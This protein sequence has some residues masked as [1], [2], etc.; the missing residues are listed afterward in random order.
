MPLGSEPSFPLDSIK[1]AAMDF[2]NA[3]TSQA[4]PTPSPS[5]PTYVEHHEPQQ[6]SENKPPAQPVQTQTEGQAQPEPVAEDAAE[7]NPTQL[8]RVTTTVDGKSVTEVL[9]G[10]QLTDRQMNARKFTQSMQ[11]VR[12]MERQAL[13]AQRG[14]AAIRQRQAEQDSIMN[15]PGRLAAYVQAKFPQILTPQQQ[16]QAVAAQ[17]VAAPTPVVD[18]QM[19]A[20]VGDVNDAVARSIASQEAELGR[21]LSGMEQAAIQRAEESASRI[22]QQTI[23]NLQNSHQVATFDRQIEDHITS[24]TQEL[25]V[26]SAIPQLNDLLRFEVSRLNPR[27]PQEMFDGLREVAAAY[28]EQIDAHYAGQ[29]ATRMA[30][31]AKLA[32]HGTEVPSGRTPQVQ[33]VAKKPF[34]HGGKGD[35]GSVTA[36]AL[37]RLNFK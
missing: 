5:A 21:R 23:A 13:E 20:S 3:D 7:L 28:A 26:L 33:P 14:I 32:T 30:A 1:E 27:T 24:L 35:W 37:A 17:Q 19:L 31:K 6:V 16:A 9:T 12:Q 22:V 29:N 36:E 11:Q 8:F 34:A 4:A 10:K 25:P 18:P 2:V 15:D